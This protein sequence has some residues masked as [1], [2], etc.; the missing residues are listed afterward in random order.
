VLIPR[1]HGAY[2]QLAFPLATALA[3]G[4]P[5]L[6]AAALAAAGVGAFLAHE[7]LLVVLG[8]R[9][10][11]AAREQAAEARRSLLVF[12][13]LA[14][15]AGA[16][17][18]A[19]D[20]ADTRWTLL[21]PAAAAVLFALVVFSGRERTFAGE[22]VAAA[23]LAA[24]AL[25]VGLAAGASRLAAGTVPIVFALFFLMATT[26]VHAIIPRGRPPSIRRRVASALT[27]I[28]GVIALALA[29]R[30]DLVAAVAPWAVL[31][32]GV[33]ALV[34]VARPPV[35]RQLRVV[36]WTLVAAT[37]ATSILLVAGLR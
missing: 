11:R 33:V 22:L 36:G 18:V 6:G 20:P 23:T 8:Q 19:L 26:A 5:T 35:P 34:L 31:P 30:A 13:G 1:E 4:R 37:A 9:G 15:V 17:A 14:I 2:G 10:S 3:I 32:V 25:P 24:F 29:S 21:V 7:S 16:A 27:T 28:T 12:G